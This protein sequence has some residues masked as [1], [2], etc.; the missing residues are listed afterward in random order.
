MH[1]SPHFN[2]IGF[3]EDFADYVGSPPVDTS[4]QEP[5]VAGEHL[6]RREPRIEPV[7]DSAVMRWA[8]QT[9]P[10]I[11]ITH[12]HVLFALASFFTSAGGQ[13]AI[14]QSRIAEEA[15]LSRQVVNPKLSDLVQA[16]LIEREEQRHGVSGKR[17]YLYRLT[18]E[19]RAWEPTPVGP[20]GRQPVNEAVLRRRIAE[21]EEQQNDSPLSS[22][23]LYNLTTTLLLTNPGQE[24]DNN[25]ST[26]SDNRTT[27]DDV[28]VVK[29]KGLQRDDPYIPSSVVDR[30]GRRIPGAR[31]SMTES[32]LMRIFH[33]QERTGLSNQD[34][35]ASWPD[36]H[37]GT[38]PPDIIDTV[39]VTKSRAHMIIR[40]IGRQP[41]AMSLP[42]AMTPDP[43]TN[44]SELPVELPPS[45]LAAADT[46]NAVLSDLELEVPR[47][48]FET[49]LKQ[50][51]GIAFDGQDLLVEVPSKFAVEWL[52]Q[53]MYQTIL[54]ALRRS[55]GQPLD[56]RFRESPEPCPV[57]GEPAQVSGGRT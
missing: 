25:S 52:E 15:H 17:E 53:R 38:P 54:R 49:W 11:K 21:M 1:D 44:A 3:Q 37:P 19:Y 27:N 50:T 7:Y 22:K 6:D 18:G 51:R 36:I 9:G 4:Y 10:K 32:Q 45:D 41:D 43:V 40:W 33:E 12:D 57:A 30:K 14:P 24:L 8:S 42:T 28:P 5:D 48:T 46:W 26:S 31:D 16:G 34:I 35:L 20:E 47:A 55:S 13:I 39:T 56:V 23:S 29:Q 2:P